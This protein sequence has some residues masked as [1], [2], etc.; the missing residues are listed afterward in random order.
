MKLSTSLLLEDI[1]WR[2]EHSLTIGQE[3]LEGRTHQKAER[4][5]PD[6]RSPRE[7]LTSKQKTRRGFETTPRNVCEK[8]ASQPQQQKAPAVV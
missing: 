5:P 8:A 4:R 6:S 2:H 7:N 1:T 3:E